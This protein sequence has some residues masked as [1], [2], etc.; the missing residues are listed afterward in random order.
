VTAVRAQGSGGNARPFLLSSRRLV[1]FAGAV[2]LPL[3]YLPITYDAF[4]IPKLALA[5]LL[6]LTLLGLLM[7]EWI[8]YRRV[9]IRRTPIDLPLL[10]FVCSAGLS[11]VLAVNQN[12]AVFGTYTRFDGLLTIAT[13]ALL[14]WLTAQSLT[15]PGDARTLI[16]SVMAGCA[17]A[18]VIGILQAVV[19]TAT[20]GGHAGETAISF[21]GIFRPTATLGNANE[22]GILLAMVLP[23][24]IHE[25]IA[26]RTWTARVTAGSAALLFFLGLTL[27]LS[28]SAWLGAAAGSLPV[29]LWRMRRRWRTALVIALPVGVL[30][31]VGVSAIRS[32]S[33]SLLGAITNRV[34]TLGD[35]TAGSAASRLH[36]WSDTAR[37]IAARPVAGWGPDSL[38]LVYP[39]YQTGNWT[40]GTTIDE[41]HS[42]VLQVG[43]TQGL[44]GVACYAG[45]LVAVFRSFM[46]GR[47]A[48]VGVALLGGVLAYQLALQFNFT[49]IPTAAPYWLL[50][51]AAVI[52]WTPRPP[53]AA[54]LNRSPRRPA[55][56][57]IAAA[58]VALAG[59][60]CGGVLAALPVAADAAFLR[61][62]DAQ[63]RG[64][65]ALARSLI[66]EARSLAPQESAYSVRAGDLALDL[67]FGDMPGPDAD[68]RAA[69]VAYTDAARL[70]TPQ[71]AAY[72]H[73]AV[74]DRALGR[75]SA[76]VAAA[77][78]A[79]ALAPY[80]GTSAEL[81]R[82]LLATS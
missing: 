16:R 27:S 49:W 73:L 59:I 43:A 12:V 10:A 65:I 46:R 30:A 22:F 70:G 68:W 1:L 66:G 36:I 6:V 75:T 5:R 32:G 2:A 28:R 81:L 14:F 29:L 40:P 44:L 48:D 54:R 67:R 58:V 31:L 63:H 18:A 26:A 20:A 35:P 4:V 33:P 79:V 80:D 42:E 21:A 50:V 61:G 11:T 25:T 51:A 8:Y 60:V 47:V 13:Y 55:A 34:A 37:L 23:L 7:A 3:A 71:A 9:R 74:A 39:H 62:L 41:A 38:G 53:A 76:A 17:F 19:A 57:A 69:V 52:T 82:E 64:D 45:L 24:A 56:A 77:R 15:G 78:Q 72:R